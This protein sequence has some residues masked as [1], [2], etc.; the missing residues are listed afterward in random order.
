[1]RYI[2]IYILGENNG[3]IYILLVR[4]VIRIWAKKIKY[5]VISFSFAWKNIKRKNLAIEKVMIYTNSRQTDSSTNDLSAEFITPLPGET[6][7]KHYNS[8]LISLLA[9]LL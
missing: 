2:V 1:M 8:R 3:A 7:Q 4:F 5:I 6:I 9:D